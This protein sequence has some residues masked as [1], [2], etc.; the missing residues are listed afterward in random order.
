MQ[1]GAKG[2]QSRTEASD[3]NFLRTRRGLGRRNQGPPQAKI[4]LIV[5]TDARSTNLDA[6]WPLYP[7]RGIIVSGIGVAAIINWNVRIA[8]RRATLDIVLNEQTHE[9]AIKERTQF[10]NLKR[11]GDLSSW[12]ASNHADSPEVETIRAVLNR[13]ELVAIGIRQSTL[14][15]KIYKR[16]CRTTLVGDWRAMKPFI[17]QIR[18]VNSIPSLYCEFEALAKKWANASEKPYV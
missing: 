13:Y 18:T 4:R 11:K 9:T 10:I 2:L 5:L 15:E 8:R 16:W 17:V 12:A 7:N 14:D 3:D 6:L 1:A